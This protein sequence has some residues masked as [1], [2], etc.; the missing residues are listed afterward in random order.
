MVASCAAWDYSPQL[1]CSGNIRADSK[2]QLQ[3]TEHNPS[4]K[5]KILLSTSCPQANKSDDIGVVKF[6]MHP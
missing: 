1:F 5:L 3:I 2:S 4:R 6:V